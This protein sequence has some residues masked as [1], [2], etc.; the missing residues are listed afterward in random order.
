MK[1]N[2]MITLAGL[3]FFGMI[4][5]SA[6]QTDWS[7][8]G[9]AL[10][11]PNTNFL[12][13][14]TNTDLVF[15]RNG[16][17]S[18]AISANNT[19]FGSGALLSLSLGTA[20]TAIGTN[21]LYGINKGSSNV[22]VGYE[23]MKS[24]SGGN[25]NIG[26]GWRALGTLAGSSN[27]VAIGLQSLYSTNGSHNTAIGHLSGYLNRGSANVFLGREAGYNEIGSNRL[28]ISNSNISNPM[29]YGEFDTKKLVF[30]VDFSASSCVEVKSA[31]TGT[32]G[33]RF[34]NLNSTS[35][36]TAN[37]NGKFLTV[38]PNGDVILESI[39]AGLGNNLYNSDGSL[40]SN[41]KVSM[42]D[43]T[44]VFDTDTNGRIYVG[45]NLP[46]FPTS[47]GNYR[48]YVE[49]GIL[50]EKVKVALTSSS[51]WA[52][53]VFADDYKLMSL[54]EVEAF[55]KANKHL[56]KIASSETLAKDGL[57]LSSMQAKQMEKI[58]ELTLYL[59]QQNKMMQKQS[60]E[61]QQLKAQVKALQTTK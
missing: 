45:D 39:P 34:A 52:D 18:G 60:E 41:R 54:P 12:G 22:A 55:V 13:T 36:V 25:N 2:S 19:S 48:L 37:S 42:A 23:S 38:A 61:I 46:T 49:G 7:T 21:A 43:Y 15:K 20:N 5:K 26:I 14:T 58:E 9:N 11:I 47:S 4:L 53:Y 40:T 27:N 50:T 6:A 17:F 24:N 59:I 28:Y 16:V 8:S 32:S 29:I 10:A 30:N 44:L 31:T 57:D 1:T 35:G 33:L 56:P 3:L 51:D